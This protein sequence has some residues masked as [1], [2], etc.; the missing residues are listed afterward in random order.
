[1]TS[2]WKYPELKV[3]SNLLDVTD[4]MLA[5][6]EKENNE[7]VEYNKNIRLKLEEVRT[8]IISDVKFL[9]GNNSNVLKYILKQ[10]IPYY[11]STSLDYLKPRI[12]KAREDEIERLQEIETNKRHSEL[13]GKAI[14]FLTDRNKIIN[15]DFDINTAIQI[16]NDIAYEEAIWLKKKELIESGTFIDFNGQDTCENCR[17][18]DGQ[19]HRCD[20]GNRRVSWTSDGDFLNPYIYG[21]AY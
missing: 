14:K 1:M 10:R 7:C 15:I 9:W 11:S 21:E 12:L 5:E 8:R 3:P 13:V 16:A 2:L 19:S 20:C 6:W 4:E 17:G 18:W